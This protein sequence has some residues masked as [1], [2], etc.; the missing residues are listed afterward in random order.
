MQVT[1]LIGMFVLMQILMSVRALIWTTVM[2][3]HSVLTLKGVIPALATRVTLEMGSTV[4][5]RYRTK[6]AFVSILL[7]NFSRFVMNYFVPYTI[8]YWWVWS[9][10]SY[11]WLQ[12]KLHWYK[13]K[14]QLYMHRWLWRKWIQMHRWITS[15]SLALYVVTKAVGW[16]S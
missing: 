14:L 9:A 12:C 1:F 6:L 8:R 5:V 4:Q 10:D 16:H 2:R 13:W 7:F 15:R 11:M 3:M